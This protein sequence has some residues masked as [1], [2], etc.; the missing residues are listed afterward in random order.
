MTSCL[1]FWRSHSPHSKSGPACP[2][3]SL[4]ALSQ[5]PL[6][7][8]PCSATIAPCAL[9]LASLHW[10]LAPSPHCPGPSQSSLQASCSGDSAEMSLNSYS[11]SL[12]ICFSSPHSYFL[13]AP[14]GIR[15]GGGA[16]RFLVCLGHCS[17]LDPELAYIEQMFNK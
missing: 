3:S 12:F 14:G 9:G 15:S 7:A 10:P 11:L 8:F 2:P 6:L 1:Y 5:H 4:S 17:I 13:S 16:Q